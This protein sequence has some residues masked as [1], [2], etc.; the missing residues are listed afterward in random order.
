MAGPGLLAFRELP[1]TM[2][3]L[4]QLDAAPGLL[5][6]DAQG[7]AHPRRFG[8]AYLPETTRRADSLCRTALAE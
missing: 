2:R 5:A 8:F 1:T 7:L 6:C 4:A 3:V